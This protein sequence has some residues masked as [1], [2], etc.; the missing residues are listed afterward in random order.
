MESVHPSGEDPD[1]PFGH[2][3]GHVE[4]SGATIAGDDSTDEIQPSSS[5]GKF[6]RTG[7]GMVL[8]GMALGLAEVFD[9][10]LREE[11]PIVQEAP[12][13][14]DIPRAVDAFIDLDDP[15][16]SS[17]VVRSWRFEVT[18]VTEATSEADAHDAH[19][20]HDA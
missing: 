2:P 13:E 8:N 14:P 9:P 15:A 4:G 17:V 1:E 3:P 10:T 20:A 12:G 16:A 6:R 11:A 18:E 19:D 5:V 7:T